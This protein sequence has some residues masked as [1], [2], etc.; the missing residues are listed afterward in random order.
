MKDKQFN[1]RLSDDD[2]KILNNLSQKLHLPYSKVIILA[3]H[4]LQYITN[5]SFKY[6]NKFNDELTIWEN[7]E[8]MRLLNLWKKI[9]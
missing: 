4:S 6:G 2:Q 1:M 8:L 9:L 5:I 3:L 7:A